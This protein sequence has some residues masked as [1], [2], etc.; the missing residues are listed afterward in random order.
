MQTLRNAAVVVTGASSGIGRATALEFARRGAR[1]ALAARRS[2]PLESA[3]AECRAAGHELVSFDE[4]DDWQVWCAEGSGL[5]LSLVHSAG[6]A[7]SCGAA[8]APSSRA[9]GEGRGTC[10]VPPCAGTG[11]GVRALTPV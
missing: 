7:A 5:V 3:A 10:L 9:R 2:E 1:V 4:D 6:A 8:P 11:P